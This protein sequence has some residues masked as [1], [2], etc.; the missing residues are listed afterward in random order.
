MKNIAVIVLLC[1]IAGTPLWSQEINFTKL[2]KQWTLSQCIDYGRQNNFQ[3]NSLRWATVSALEDLAQA[4][5][6]RLPLV[7]GTITQSMVHSKNANPIIGG[8]QTQSKYANN[9]GVSSS[10]VVFNGGYL[11]NSIKQSQLSVLSA[12]LFVE[13]AVND[14]TLT[15]TQAFLNILLA[16]ENIMSFEQ[17]RNTSEAQLKQ[18]QQRYEQGSISK[19][20]LLQLE[21]QLA[22]DNYNLVNARNTY[23]LDLTNLKQLLQLPWNYDLTVSSPEIIEPIQAVLSLNEAEQRALISRPEI[24]SKE[25]AVDLSQA[26]L[27]RYRAG[28][29]PSV[30]LGAGLSSG[31]S[32][33]QSA[34]Y[35]SQLNNNF[36]QTLSLNASV[37]IFNRRQNLTNIAKSKIVIAQAKLALQE[38]TVT[39][40]QQIEEAYINV[41]NAQA[42]FRAAATQLKVSEETYKIT[43][44][45][46][47]YGAINM[48][49]LLQQ[50]TSYVQAMQAFLQ[51]KYAAVLYAKIYQFYAG[52]AIDL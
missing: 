2:P 7:A 26:E 10:I 47:K 41:Q 9:Y 51:S 45:Q 6:N 1:C 38:A 27:R 25:I 49:D 18:G 8:F 17:M 39:L 32:D 31:Y 34:K 48:V 4:E 14:L 37:P 23:R 46:F 36:Y 35:F 24:K 30:S 52:E 29:L 44:E 15:I 20:E 12:N 22:S 16:K 42:Q 5:N 33:N 13:E 11:K 3:I 19:K 21:S 28:R 40:N 43:Q 50:R